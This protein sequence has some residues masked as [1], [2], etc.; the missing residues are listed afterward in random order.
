[1]RLR[2]G[3]TPA[4]AEHI[5]DFADWILSIGEGKIG[6]KNDGHAVVEFP[7]EMLIP[8]SDDHIE[9]LIQETYENWGQNLWDQ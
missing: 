4:D 3:C 1:M 7:K 9:A 8:D 5:K 2:I 6:G